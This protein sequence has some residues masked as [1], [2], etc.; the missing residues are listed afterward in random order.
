[1]FTTLHRAALAF[2]LLAAGLAATAATPVPVRPNETIA[3]FN[4][5]D[6]TGLWSWL[7]DTRHDDPRRV[8]SVHDGMIHISGDGFGYLATDREY[9]DYRVVVEYR[10]GKKTDG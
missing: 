4:G 5:G 7:R 1:M 6:L 2:G 9:R 3:L 8:F 10:W